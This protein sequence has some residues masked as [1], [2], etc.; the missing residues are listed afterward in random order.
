MR[1][2]FCMGLKRDRAMDILAVDDE[3]AIRSVV[4]D[5]LEENGHSVKIA[6]SGE[7][8]L[9][10]IDADGAPALLLTDID[11]GPGINGVALASKLQMRDPELPV[12]FISGRPWLLLGTPIGGRIQFLQKPFRLSQLVEMIRELVALRDAGQSVPQAAV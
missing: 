2:P 8:A 5:L 11:L 4:A 7:E 9:S 3:E 12:I 1:P 6:G 10:I